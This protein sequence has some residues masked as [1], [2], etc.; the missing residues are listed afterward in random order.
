MIE[1]RY[2]KQILFRQIGPKGQEKISQST[3][4]VI[5]LGALGTVI[6]THLCRAGVG[7][8]RLIDRDFVELTNLQR[9]FLFD[10]KD[11][12]SRL[13]KAV[14]AAEKLRAVNSEIVIEEM[15]AD[16]TARNAEHLISGADVILDG[17]DNL[18]TRFL[19]NDVALKSMKPWVYGA[20]LGA[21]GMTMAIIPGQTPCLRCFVPRIPQPGTMPNCDTEGVLSAVTAVIASLQSAEALKILTGAEP[22]QSLLRIDVWAGEFLELSVRP[23][24]ECPACGKG[25]Y[26][27]LGGS[28]L[29][30][31]TVL[32]GRNSVQIA[33]PEEREISLKALQERLA[34]VGSTTFNGFLLTLETEG[35]EMTVFPTGRAIIRGTT[36]E[37]EART[38]YAKYVGL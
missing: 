24:P 28:H 31:T 9:Q 17:T 3:A 35:R 27:Y 21:E 19:I 6:S 22:R 20:V 38:F 4:V 32:C 2:A 18:E 10:E 5:G 37:A 30:Y 33:P 1:N 12:R 25:E 26:E 11:A 13:P 7:R 23:R 15:I 29:S 8:L 14:A 34:R 16:L 36:D